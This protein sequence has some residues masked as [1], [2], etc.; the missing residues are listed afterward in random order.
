M[1][2]LN[3]IY[4]V[5]TGCYSE[6]RVVGVYSTIE[7]AEYARRLF[8]STNEIEELTVDDL[9]DHPKDMTYWLCLMD[10]DGNARSVHQTEPDFERDSFYFAAGLGWF[11]ENQ[12]CMVFC[13]WARDEKH[14]VKIA[15]EKRIILKANGQWN[16]LI[17]ES[18]HR[19]NEVNR[20]LYK[21]SK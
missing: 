20:R 21:D 7:V 12:D 10:I 5:S 15:N 6:Y 1:T 9:V 8:N 14:A 16:D 13:M 11:A 3:K 17:A 2:E 18:T 4:M 19:R